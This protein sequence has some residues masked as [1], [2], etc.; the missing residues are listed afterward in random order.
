MK[1]PNWEHPFEVMCDISDQAIK[2]ILKQKDEGKFYVIYY[3]SRTLNPAQNN[4]A[5]TKKMIYL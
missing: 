5:T 1:G 3:A 2:V 4:Y